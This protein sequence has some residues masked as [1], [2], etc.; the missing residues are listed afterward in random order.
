M[1][2]IFIMWL[3]LNRHLVPHLSRIVRINNG[4]PDTIQTKFGKVVNY[5]NSYCYYSIIVYEKSI[6]L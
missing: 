1:I 4:I 5:L 6:F 3:Q 2:T